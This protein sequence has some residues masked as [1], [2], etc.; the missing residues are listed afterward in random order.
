MKQSRMRTEFTEGRVSSNWITFPVLVLV[1]F[2]MFLCNPIGLHAEVGAVVET[3]DISN[4]DADTNPGII[5]GTFS[6]YNGMMSDLDPDT[7]AEVKS[8]SRR[9]SINVDS[10][11]R[12]LCNYSNDD[13]RNF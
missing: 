1:C 12:R 10:S 13:G 9:I 5:K 7:G 6:E 2:C 3:W 8:P 4:T 11:K